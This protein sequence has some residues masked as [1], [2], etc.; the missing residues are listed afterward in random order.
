MYQCCTNHNHQKHRKR[1]T[2]SQLHRN[3]TDTQLVTLYLSRFH[4]QTWAFLAKQSC[5]LNYY[6]ISI[7]YVIDFYYITN[8]KPQTSNMV[9]RLSGLERTYIAIW[10]ICILHCDLCMCTNC[11]R[12]TFNILFI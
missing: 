7:L 8:T 3:Y 9:I 11:D 12:K 5:L 2:T 6:F 4:R 10:I 1:S